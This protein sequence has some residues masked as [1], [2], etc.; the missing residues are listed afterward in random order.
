MKNIKTKSF[1]F[2]FLLSMGSAQAEPITCAWKNSKVVNVVFEK[3][4]NPNYI[5]L[6][7]IVNDKGISGDF[8]IDYG[9]NNIK[10]NQV[11]LIDIDT[12][13]HWNCPNIFELISALI[14]K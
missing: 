4:E 7:L 1:A 10:Y 14:P 11:A 12:M 8:D 6:N 3:A 5:F 9:R 2:L 13:V